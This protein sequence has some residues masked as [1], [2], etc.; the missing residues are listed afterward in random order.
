MVLQDNDR[1]LM[2]A[3]SE[4]PGHELVDRHPFGPGAFGQHLE[5]LGRDIDLHADDASRRPHRHHDQ[6]RAQGP[7]GHYDDLDE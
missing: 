2:V 4:H 1:I 7:P 5:Q 6:E 3:A